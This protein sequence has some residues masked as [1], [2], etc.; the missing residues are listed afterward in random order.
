MSERVRQ[1]T[2]PRGLSRAI[3][4]L[5][6]LLYPIGLGGLLGRRFLRLTHRGRHSGNWHHTVLEVVDEDADHG[7]ISVVSAWGDRSDWLRNVRSHSE[8]EIQIGRQ[9]TAATARLL[10]EEAGEAVLR[11]YAERHPAAARGLARLLG[12]RLSDPRRDFGVLARDMIVVEL[13][14]KPARRPGP[15]PE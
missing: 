12:Y 14:L 6:L 8:V 13:T 7:R 11:S 2:A 5:P 4:R 15:I 1:V 10:A 9:R 3:F